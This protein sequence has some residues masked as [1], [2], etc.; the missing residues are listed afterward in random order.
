MGRVI[1]A[2]ALVLMMLTAASAQELTS[3]S[4]WTNK[5]QS[6]LTISSIDAKGGFKGTFVN[7][8][9]GYRC[10]GQP[11]DVS[12]QVYGDEVFFA[13]SFTPCFSLVIWKGQL[14]GNTIST[15]WSLEHVTDK[16]EFETKS[17]ED[18]FTKAN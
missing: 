7:N 18:E 3:P 8:A 12:G 2:F 15:S 6:V 5:R 1:V 16:W 4:K 14:A 10:V 17:G 11:F 9:T 13:V